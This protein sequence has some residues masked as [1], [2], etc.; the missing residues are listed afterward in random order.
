LI[1]YRFDKFLVIAAIFNFQFTDIIMLLP[2]LGVV[3]ARSLASKLV[4]EPL[5]ILSSA[6]AFC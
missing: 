1:F 2:I 6:R 3:K 5:D 4:F